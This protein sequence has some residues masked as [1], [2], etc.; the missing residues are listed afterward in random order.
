MNLEPEGLSPL[1]DNAA[2]RKVMELMKKIH[3]LGHDEDLDLCCST[4][5]EGAEKNSGHGLFRTGKCAFYFS[6]PSVGT[7][8]IVETGM[9]L[10]NETEYVYQH[11]R[12]GTAP[13]PGW[14]E[15]LDRDTDTLMPCTK[16]ECPSSIESSGGSLLNRVS[17]YAN[18]GMGAVING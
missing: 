11:G 15:Y 8:S 10:F 18:G 9:N 17:W 16:V 14:A 2:M 3:E 4:K 12:M 5:D 13:L 7:N 1:V 6:F